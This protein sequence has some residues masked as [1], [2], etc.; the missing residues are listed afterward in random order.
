MAHIMARSLAQTWE[1]WFSR[2][3][4]IAGVWMILSPWMIGVGATTP[5]GFSALACGLIIAAA[6]TSV[7][8]WQARLSHQ[9]VFVIALIAAAMAGIAVV[10]PFLLQ[11]GG[12]ARWS[13]ILAGMLVIVDVGYELLNLNA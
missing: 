2:I 8:I 7:T 4:L 11:F 9:G 5:A 13:N 12:L 3:A 10:A 1:R 6:S